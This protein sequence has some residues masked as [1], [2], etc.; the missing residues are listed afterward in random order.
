MM[1][2]YV[3]VHNLTKRYKRYDKPSDRLKEWLSF[4]KV[5]RH[6]SHYAL[7]N[8]SFE[9][10]PGEAVGIIGR[11]GAGKSTLLKIITGTT[12]PTKGQV[13]L[14]GRVA[15]LLE[16]GMGFHPDYT[17]RENVFMAGQLLG[18][19]R[20]EIETCFSDIEKFAE[21]GDYMN[22][23]LR[24]YSSGM[25]VRLAFSVATAI[26]PDI[27]IIDEALSVG[28]IHFQQK[29]SERICQFK[30]LGTT[31]LFVSHD[32]I[33][34]N[35]I[36]DRVLFIKDSQIA[37]D[38]IP[39]TAID[40][41]EVQPYLN[42]ENTALEVNKARDKETLGNLENQAV[43]LI[44]VEIL[45]N[46]EPASSI[47]SDS[48]VSLSIKIL[49]LH[50]FNDPHVGFKIRDRLGVVMFETNSFC[51]RKAIG[52]VN[53]NELLT[54]NFTFKIGLTSGEYTVTVG[55]AN[56][57]YAETEFQQPLIYI[58]KALKFTVLTNNDTILWAGIYNLLPEFS[59]VKDSSKI[60]LVQNDD[61][62]EYS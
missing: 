14:Q 30:K 59:F 45:S 34:I 33:T 62:I 8:I 48:E 25:Q 42:S 54:I 26:R 57:G 15:A 31:L 27:L 44:S 28:D 49:F 20:Q 9:I 43:Q 22:Q 58:H 17:G 1:N 6:H 47:M 21:I 18:L 3:K 52:R 55:V 13:Q 56:E 32:L 4:R 16:L 29:C 51:M 37:Y 39:S 50:A 24:I 2:G 12:Q 23:P 7:N 53:K 41:Y 10:Q 60:G 36:C 61:P 38:G 46:G 40:L 35:R 19:S 11:N 5:P